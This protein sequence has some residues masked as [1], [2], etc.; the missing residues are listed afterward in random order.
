MNGIQNPIDPAVAAAQERHK[1][2]LQFARATFGLLGARIG[3]NAIPDALMLA[4]HLL[5]V[6]ADQKVHPNLVSVEIERVQAAAKEA[7]ALIRD[8]MDQRV[9]I[10][11]R[12]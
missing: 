10:F 9:Q 4:M 12:V 3:P 11:H 6:V 8:R 1:S 2:A 5:D 7:A